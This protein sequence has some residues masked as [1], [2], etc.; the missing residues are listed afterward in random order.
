MPATV[1][2]SIPAAS[3][4]DRQQEAVL[5]EVKKKLAVNHKRIE[6]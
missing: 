5:N 6:L 3:E 4:S 2:G 1:P